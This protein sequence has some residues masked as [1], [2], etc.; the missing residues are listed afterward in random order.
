MKNY[1][2]VRLSCWLDGRG[3]HKGCCVWCSCSGEQKHLLK[4]QLGHICPEKA[5][6]GLNVLRALVFCVECFGGSRSYKRS[7]HNSMWWGCMLL[8]LLN[9]LVAT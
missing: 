9:R 6:L 2:G 3:V 8:L 4:D 7:S 1:F 5:H